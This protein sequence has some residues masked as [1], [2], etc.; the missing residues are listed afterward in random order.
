MVPIVS[1][2]HW[3]ANQIARRLMIRTLWPIKNGRYRIHLP[4]ATG[5]GKISDVHFLF[6]EINTILKWTKQF[7]QAKTL[8]EAKISQHILVGIGTKKPETV[9]ETF[10]N[11]FA[12]EPKIE[13]KKGNERE[14]R[15]GEGKI[16]FKKPRLKRN[17]QLRTRHFGKIFYLAIRSFWP[18][19]SP[20]SKYQIV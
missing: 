7:Y 4:L 12:R 14:R 16:F 10:Q 18:F 3:I 6:D 13:F 20:E 5:I 15:K 17:S 8:K 19:V 1:F 2:G 11:A 9:S